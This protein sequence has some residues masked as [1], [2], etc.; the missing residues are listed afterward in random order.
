M[1]WP[2]HDILSEAG[3]EVEKSGKIRRLRES[4]RKKLEI[5]EMQRERRC[6]SCGGK[7]EKER[8]R[9]EIESK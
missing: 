2:A 9:T 1:P 5:C 7:G 3:R 8:V 6:K 4:A